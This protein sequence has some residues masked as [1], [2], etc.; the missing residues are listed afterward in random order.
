MA[1]LLNL[2]KTE[3]WD[4]ILISAHLINKKSMQYVCALMYMCACVRVCVCVGGVS[5]RA[6]V[7]LL[8]LQTLHSDIKIVVSICDADLCL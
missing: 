6:W 4:F 8:Y 1:I 2:V 7:L 3:C 5:D